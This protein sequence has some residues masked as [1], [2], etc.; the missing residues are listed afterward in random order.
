MLTIE[1]FK[2]RLIRA[3]H[4]DWLRVVVDANN[5]KQFYIVGNG[6]MGNTISAPI[7]NYLPEIKECVISMINSGKLI[8]AEKQNLL[9]DR[10]TWVY[11]LSLSPSAKGE[12]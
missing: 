2:K 7:E 11:Y 9:L 5:K 3:N 10:N 4:S 1:K 6:G 12:V 8:K